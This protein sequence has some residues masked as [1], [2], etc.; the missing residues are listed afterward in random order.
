MTTQER[1]ELVQAA[2]ELV[3]E[4]QNIMDDAMKGYDGEANYLSYG[5]YGFSQLLGNGNPY[6]S[7]LYSISESLEEDLEYYSRFGVPNN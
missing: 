1:L 5:K 6:D 4:A 7:S 2:Q 3:I